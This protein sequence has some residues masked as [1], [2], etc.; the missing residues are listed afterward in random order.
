MYNCREREKRWGY[1]AKV[2]HGIKPNGKF[3][4]ICLLEIKL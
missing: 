2:Y 4:K 3:D 1:T